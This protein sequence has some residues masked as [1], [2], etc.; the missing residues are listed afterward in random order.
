VAIVNVI[1]LIA[2]GGLAAAEPLTLTAR[3]WPA[4]HRTDA[5]ATNSHMANMVAALV[6]Q[7]QAL[8]VVRHAGGD[9][10]ERMANDLRQALV[11]LGV[12]SARV[13][14]EPAAAASGQLILELMTNP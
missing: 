2:A 9:A 3:E 11:S 13:R 4:P 14:F 8:L 6:S 10:G 1:M 7:E 12:P 5:L